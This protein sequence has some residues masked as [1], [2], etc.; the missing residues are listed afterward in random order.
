M[1]T[2]REREFIKFMLY[3]KIW[4]ANFIMRLISIQPSFGSKWILKKIKKRQVVDDF[5]HAP[6]CPANHYHR[7]RLV[8]KS[9]SCG[10]GYIDPDENEN[11]IKEILLIQDRICGKHHG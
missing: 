7:T 2:D 1:I 11:E 5:H 9:C 10:A 6:C 3:M 8:F 4:K